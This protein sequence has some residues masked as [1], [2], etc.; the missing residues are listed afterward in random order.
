MLISINPRALGSWFSIF[1]SLQRAMASTSS[2]R[3]PQR[4]RTF[5]PLN[6]DVDNARGAR[7]LQGIVF[8]V[9]GTLW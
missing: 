4:P 1:S 6:P 5:A 3:P 9:D 2:L 8:D 7:K